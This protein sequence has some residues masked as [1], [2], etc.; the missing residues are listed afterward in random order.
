MPLKI[1]IVGAGLAGL[2]AAIDLV[3]NGHDVEIFE[4]SSFM[5]EVGAAIHVAPNAS[6]IL[7]QWGC[8]RGGLQ[9]VDC[10]YLSLY[11]SEGQ[12]IF[13]PVETVKLNRE[14]HIDDDWWL[15]HRVD[16]HNE[17]RRLV[18]KGYNGR[19]ATIHLRSKV[20]QVNANRGE[21]ITA[22]GALHTADLIVGADGVHSKSV[23]A[24][25]GVELER[26]STMQNCFRFLIPTE[27]L[28]KDPLTAELVQKAGLLQG[29]SSFNGRAKRMVV[30]PC[31]EGEL[32]NCAAIYGTESQDLSNESSWLASGNTTDLLEIF[33]DFSPA[34]RKL[35][36]YGEDVKLWSLASRTA[37]KVFYK[38]R[39]VLIGDAAHPT[40]PHQGQGGAQSFEDAA[41]LGALLTSDTT[42]IDL[43]RKLQLFN[44][45]RYD[46]AITVMYMSRVENER[47]HEMLDDL[48]QFVPEAT[49]PENMFAYTWESFPVKQ[50][51]D[52]LAADAKRDAHDSVLESNR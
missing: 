13:T 30:Y 25:A 35:C 15:T 10:K 28:R 11:D 38:D 9:P 26:Q 29:C 36:E 44:Q 20:S 39:L 12:H 37:P 18:E 19:R 8:T 34:L 2:G 16:L 40:L 1:I 46:R 3:R 50:A 17:L 7:K 27:T 47:R 45:I 43:P 14:L 32:L 33:R 49:V 24:L 41:A 23:V 52:L 21:I 5:N 51:K 6:R 48:R 42:V 4:Q 22:D 31:R